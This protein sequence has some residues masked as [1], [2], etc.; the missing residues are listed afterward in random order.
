MCNC[1][2]FRS[3]VLLMAVLSSFS[4]V[5]AAPDVALRTAAE[6]AQ[7]L[8]IESLREMVLI[9]S[10]SA[11]VKGLAQMANLV[12]SRLKALALSPCA[13]KPPPVRAPTLWWVRCKARA[14]KIHAASPHG[15]GVLSWH[16]EYARL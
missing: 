14:G 6:K 12:E 10:G 1:F 13:T 9:E 15:H 5:Q 4:M 3:V 2:G 16:L 8:L 7:P 11:D